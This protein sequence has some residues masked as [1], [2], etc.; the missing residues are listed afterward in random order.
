MTDGIAVLADMLLTFR[1]GCA[2]TG[3]LP[4]YPVP[5]PDLDSRTDP[6][7]RSRVDL[8]RGVKQRSNAGGDVRF[9]G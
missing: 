5:Y 1:K 6:R 3:D 8:V 7:E 4:V 9:S 2:V